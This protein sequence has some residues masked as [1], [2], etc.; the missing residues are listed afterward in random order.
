[1]IPYDY[2]CGGWQNLHLMLSDFVEIYFLSI[3]ICSTDNVRKIPCRMR[4]FGPA[5]LLC[6][7]KVKCSN[8]MSVSN[9]SC[10]QAFIVN[11]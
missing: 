3:K 9:K 10:L 5:L 2:V 7:N 11:V 4:S 8:N 6:Q 1:M